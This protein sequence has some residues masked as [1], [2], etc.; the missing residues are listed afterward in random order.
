MMKKQFLIDIDGVTLLWT[1]GFEK[2]IKHKRGIDLRSS[3]D[4]FYKVEK[5]L[6]IS[7]KEA[8][9][10]I[11]D[12]HES[13]YFRHLP[14]FR[15]ALKYIPKMKNEGWNFTAITA[16][17]ISEKIR[18]NRIFNLKKYFGNSITDLI[19]VDPDTTKLDKLQMFEPSY[20]IDD[21]PRHV[22]AGIEAG[23]TS[24]HMSRKHHEDDVRLN[25]PDIIPVDNWAEV[26]NY[27]DSK[28]NR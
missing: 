27:V 11:L 2:Y 8:H 18:E 28:T 13:E 23:H 22:L 9:E 26:Y 12:F 4:Q 24:F 10:L 1:S 17:G 20:W 14:P 6:N 16:A 25:H 5:V 15:D 3:P 7:H 19:L 21:S